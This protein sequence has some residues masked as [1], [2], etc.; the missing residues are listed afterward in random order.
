MIFSFSRRCLRPF[1]AA[2]LAVTIVILSASTTQAAPIEFHYSGTITSADA[3]TGI[4][5]GSHFDGTFTYDPQTDPQTMFIENARNYAFGQPNHMPTAAP[6][7]TSAASL[8]IGGSS[9]FSH[10]GGLSMQVQEVGRGDPYNP[11]PQTN[12]NIT[13]YDPNSRMSVGVLL[14][15]PGRGVLGSLDVPTSIN[16]AD[17]PVSTITISHWDPVQKVVLYD[18]GTIDSLTQVGVTT[19]PEPASVALW[20][21]FAASAWAVRARSRRTG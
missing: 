11:N 18:R 1:A 15:N 6:P 19:V 17:F 21:G 9:I 16:F 14:G 12:L 7:D 2:G 8:W 20:L 10:Q 13:S 4:A 3:G 5:V